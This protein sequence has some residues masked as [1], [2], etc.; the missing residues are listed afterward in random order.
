MFKSMLVICVAWHFREAD[1]PFKLEHVFF[2]RQDV[3]T[4]ALASGGG[5]THSQCVSQFGAG[6]NPSLQ[7]G[8]VTRSLRR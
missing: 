2:M 4:G 6:R 7:S 3:A 5:V 1:A 8:I